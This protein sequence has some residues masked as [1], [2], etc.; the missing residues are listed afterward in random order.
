VNAKNIKKTAQAMTITDS[1]IQNK[2]SFSFPKKKEAN[3]LIETNLHKFKTIFSKHKI[4]AIGLESGFTKRSSK[5]SAYNFLLTMIIGSLDT[6]HTSLEKMC[7]ILKQI[8]HKKQI[9]SQSLMERI[10]SGIT[11]NFLKII[12][13]EILKEKLLT[14]PEIP[15]KLLEKFKKVL[16]QDSSTATLHEELQ[17]EF[18]GSG[19]RSS[20]S[21]VKFDVIYDY[22]AKNYEY[23]KLTDQREADQKLANNIINAVT[24]ES[25]V[26]RD[27][28]YLNVS[29]LIQII[30]KKA[31]FLSRMRS[32]TLV[33]LNKEDE[34]SID[35]FDYIS[36][37]YSD[38]DVIDL[39]VFI[40]AQKLPVRLVIYRAPPEVV[41]KRRRE[42]IATAKKQG[43]TLREK[44]LRQMNF[45]TFITNVSREFW[46]PEIIGTIYRIRW[47]IE[48]IFKCWKSRMSI[49]HL[50]GINADRIRCLL[51]ARL[52]L[53]LLV[54]FV[55]KL[56]EFI[57]ICVLQKNMSMP[58]VYEWVRNPERLLRLI[59]GTMYG[60]EKRLFIDTISK[61]M[62]TQKRNRKSTLRKICEQ[63]F[64]GI[65]SFL[66]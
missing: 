50:Q 4:H 49:H 66:A 32:D 42:A 13:E 17:N 44:T 45:T 47:Q 58:K 46:K 30:A 27:L 39:D 54:N 41:N 34:N 5:I 28:G 56:A 26:I 35:I 7:D 1:T 19:G 10:N 20:K 15:A 65:E 14:L 9:S 37:Y 16:L 53:L 25:L 64:F 36:N 8:N 23:I 48:L 3:T 33:F 18:K 59:K 40:T 24:E 11:V 63:D 57:G 52:I 61:G 2:Q 31:F 21:T 22:K 29:G 43:R 55:Y 38:Y 51:Y 62:Y 60:W 12:Y 6:A